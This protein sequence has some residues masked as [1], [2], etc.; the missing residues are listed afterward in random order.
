MASS[1]LDDPRV[2]RS[3][4]ARMMARRNGLIVRK[5]RL[6]KE[7]SQIQEILLRQYAAGAASTDDWLDDA[8]VRGGR[9]WPHHRGVDQVR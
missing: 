9:E 2:A 7:I 6:E 8:P 5:N 3:L 4:L 1:D